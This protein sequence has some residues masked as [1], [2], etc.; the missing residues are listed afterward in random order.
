[1]EP[2][3]NDRQIPS[4]DSNTL[5]RLTE[6]SKLKI[7]CYQLQAR[8]HATRT[9]R[10]YSYPVLTGYTRELVE[11]EL[12]AIKLKLIILGDKS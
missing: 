11:K 2:S 6:I 5:E 1:M 9:S 7:A 10:E 3:N 12:A 4:I 8:L